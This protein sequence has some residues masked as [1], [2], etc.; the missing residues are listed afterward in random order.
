MA[1]FNALMTCLGNA[2]PGGATNSLQYKS[3]TG[4]LG[5]VSP[6]T[7]G[8]IAIGSTGAAPQAQS[9]T[10]GSGILITNAPGSITI[11]TSGSAA[12]AGLYRQVTSATPTSAATGL[13]TWL[14]QGSSVVSDSSVGLSINAPSVS[15]D[16]VVG[17]YKVAPSPPYTITALVAGTR[18]ATAFSG[19]GIGWYDGTNKIHVL[20]YVLNNG[21]VPILQVNR[22]N[23]PTSFNANDF[24]SGSQAFAQPIWLQINDDATNV[25]F[26]FSQDGANFLQVFSTAKSAGF[27]GASGYSNL[28]FFVN[29]SGGRTLGTLMSWT[30]N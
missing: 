18:T 1:N 30:Q 19:V 20:S 10:A 26:S 17:R 28:I 22:W 7:D 3:G 4:T 13:S 9:L 27:L 5:G 2:S 29:P 6:L 16:G 15:G 14:N 24:Q 12:G 23:T 25:S 21:G 11:A 8:Q